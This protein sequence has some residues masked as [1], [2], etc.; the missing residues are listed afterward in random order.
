MSAP[1]MSVIGGPVATNTRPGARRDSILADG[2]IPDNV[3]AIN[4]DLA[5]RLSQ[6]PNDLREAY[7]R[8][9]YGGAVRFHA[10]WAELVETVLR[11]HS[12]RLLLSS[13]RARALS[14]C[15]AC[16]RLGVPVDDICVRSMRLRAVLDPDQVYDDR[17]LH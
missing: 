11:V 2:A 16:L 6:A 9:G 4:H 3:V 12:F 10:H 8:D 17:P 1:S 5:L 14:S 13:T 7:A 15:D